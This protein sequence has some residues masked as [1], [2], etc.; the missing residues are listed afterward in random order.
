MMREHSFGQHLMASSSLAVRWLA[1]QG[2]CLSSTVL[3]LTFPVINT[4]ADAA[5]VAIVPVVVTVFQYFAGFLIQV[6]KI[7]CVS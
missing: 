2:L 5:A 7:R 6:E 4:P 3:G 1:M